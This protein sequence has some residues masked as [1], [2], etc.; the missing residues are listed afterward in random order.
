[1]NSPCAARFQ[2]ASP[3]TVG[4]RVGIGVNKASTNPELLGPD[5]RTPIVQQHEVI[6]WSEGVFDRSVF[7]GVDSIQL[8]LGGGVLEYEDPGRTIRLWARKMPPAFAQKKSCEVTRHR[9]FCFKRRH[10]SDNSQLRSSLRGIV[11]VER[12]WL[13]IGVA[14]AAVATGAKPDHSV[15]IV[16]VGKEETDASIAIEVILQQ[17]KSRSE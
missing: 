12:F 14:F 17:L 2:G 15:A 9:S 6:I 5:G 7:D 10:A 11:D 16:N 13:A 8:G 4:G 3:G 1:M